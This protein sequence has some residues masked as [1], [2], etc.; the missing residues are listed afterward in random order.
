MEAVTPTTLTVSQLNTYIKSVFDQDYRLRNILVVGEISNF[1]AARSGH[2][3]MT[4]KDEQS[5]LKAVMFRG[6][7][8]RLKFRPENGMRVI[9]FGSVSVYEAGGQYQLYINDLQPDGLGSLNLAFEQLKER[10]SKEGLFDPGY[11][12]PLPSYPKRIGVVTSPTAAAFQDICN[13]LQRRW[14]GAEVVLSPT[15]VQGT[16]APPQIVQALQRLDAEGVDVILLARGGGSMED[17]WAFNDEGVAR[18]V[19]ACR[20]P[21]VSGVGHETDFTIA[22][23]VADLRAPTPSAAAELSTPDWYDESDRILQYSNRM[24]SLMQNRLNLSRSH[25][26]ELRTSNV[27]RSF[28]S[29]VNEKRL[30]IDQMTDVMVRTLTE[31]V[32][33]E[34]LQLDRT[35]I[36]LD[37]AAS[38]RLTREQNRFAKA[39]AKMEA[40][41]PF[42]VLSRGYSIAEREDGSIVRSVRNVSKNDKLSVRV[43]D[44]TIACTVDETVEKGNENG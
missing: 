23:F 44:G 4:L 16:D 21:V 1:T 17:L 6:S 25:L 11:K 14:P 5:A 18:A 19:F 22:D 7:A 24:R 31:R 40:Y 28:G 27:L 30:K 39:C 32:R 34:G 37:H 15:L 10:L 42:A 43:S 38:D 9:A 36:R 26:Q 29:L 8:S 20:T 3:Y 33:T 13:V 35:S 2:L 41:D 12:K